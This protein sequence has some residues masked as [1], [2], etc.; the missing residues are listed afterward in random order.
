MQFLFFF[1]IFAV[2]LRKI[3]K[4]VCEWQ[5][6]F[7]QC[8][9]HAIFLSDG[10]TVSNILRVN[11]FQVVVVR[12]LEFLKVQNFNCHSAL[13]GQYAL[14]C[15]ILCHLVEPLRRRPFFSI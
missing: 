8:R 2:L 9:H 6:K 11:G 5:S 4:V 10:S 3:V 14:P 13:E 12:H 7:R 1:I 15:T